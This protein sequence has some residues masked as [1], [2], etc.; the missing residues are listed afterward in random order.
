[1]K[2]R[3]IPLVTLSCLIT[4]FVVHAA[5]PHTFQGG[6]PAVASEVN[7]NFSDLDTRLSKLEP[8]SSIQ[9]SDYKFQYSSVGYAKNVGIAKFTYSDYYAYVVK[10][11]YQND[12][13]SE[14]AEKITANGV[15]TAFPYMYKTINVTTDLSGNV[16]SINGSVWGT[17]SDPG[18]KIGRTQYV[19]N[20]TYDT[21][22]T[23]K[24]VTQTNLKDEVKC[25][26]TGLIRHCIRKRTNQSNDKVSYGM[27][28]DAIIDEYEPYTDPVSGVVINKVISVFRS[29]S[30]MTPELNFRAPGIAF[31]GGPFDADQ[32][33]IQFYHLNGSSQ[34][35]LIGTPFASGQP[36]N[37]KFF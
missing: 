32:Y 30:G 24:Q 20:F 3:I 6:Q 19:E 15:A 23:N 2:K 35:T 21:D 25:N 34:G 37:G 1:M 28:S 14:A 29:G 17:N 11:V 9:W 16:T 10:L 36:L 22:G 8:L 4:S 5:V 31:I 27:F 12:T 7:E 33:E 18:L 13:S 26:F